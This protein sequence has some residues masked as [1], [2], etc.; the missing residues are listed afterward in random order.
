MKLDHLMETTEWFCGQDQATAVKDKSYTITFCI[1]LVH[2]S[3][4]HNYKKVNIAVPP[5]SNRYKYQ[6]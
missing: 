3:L 6:A 1:E 5:T 2:K 4:L